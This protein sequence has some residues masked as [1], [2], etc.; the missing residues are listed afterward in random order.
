MMISNDHPLTALWILRKNI[1][2]TGV[3]PIENIIVGKRFNPFMELL[4]TKGI[5]ISYQQ[6]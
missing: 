5:E 4:Q 2:E 1:T 6:L 3:V